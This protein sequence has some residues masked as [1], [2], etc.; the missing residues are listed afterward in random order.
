MLINE[1]CKS[2]LLRKNINAYPATATKDSIERYQRKLR[3]ILDQSS[4]LSTPQ[5]AEQVYA[6]QIK[7]FGAAR[8]FSETKRYYNSLMLSLYPHM[9]SRV[10][11][12]EDRLK[13]AVQYAMVGN[14]IDFGASDSVDENV[15]RQQLDEAFSLKID[16]KILNS[17]REEV[18]KARRLVL[19]TDNCGEIVTDKLFISVLRQL[20]PELYVTII[21]RG[22]PVLNDATMED[23]IQVRMEEAAQR[24]IGNGTGMPGNVVGAVSP[25]AMEEMR[26]ADLLI[27]KGQ[28]NY[29]GLSECG[30]N[31][32][33][34]FLCKCELFMRRFNV[35]QYTGI[36]TWESN[37]SVEP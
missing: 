26:K 2:C 28:G 31:I 14:Y 15:L 11:A 13:A 18:H 30:L 1:I 27:A 34:F 17:F 12:S 9:E 10:N 20:N 16:P 23:A 35:P 32:F 3:D 24:V 5:V 8:D 29:E 7:A 6:V 25:E 37:K 36:L 21:V 33:Y 19:F 22:Q 4:G